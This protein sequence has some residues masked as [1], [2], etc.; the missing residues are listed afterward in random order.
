MSFLFFFFQSFS[1]KF[2]CVGQQWKVLGPYSLRCRI[3]DPS[4]QV[5]KLALQI[6]KIKDNRYLLDL[7]KISGETFFMFDACANFFNELKL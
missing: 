7:K 1:L 3:S 5:V 2:L 4:G 6:Y